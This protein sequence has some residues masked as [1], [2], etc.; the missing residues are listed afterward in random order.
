[1]I[2]G[3]E[4]MIRLHALLHCQRVAD[5][6]IGE[7]TLLLGARAGLL[8]IQ[9]LGTV[10]EDFHSRAFQ[11]RCRACDRSR[12]ILSCAVAGGVDDAREAVQA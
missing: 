1:M 9:K 7:V 11:E 8:V 10:F 2:V 4:E 5:L 3:V 12:I 6:A